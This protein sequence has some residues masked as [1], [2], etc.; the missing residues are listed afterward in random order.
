MKPAAARVGRRD[1]HRALQGREVRPLVELQ[2]NQRPRDPGL[3]DAAAH[4]FERGRVLVNALAGDGQ[5]QA[6]DAQVEA[7]RLAAK[8]KDLSRALR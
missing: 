4:V 2:R 3:H 1:I 7:L 5:E 8:S 6:T